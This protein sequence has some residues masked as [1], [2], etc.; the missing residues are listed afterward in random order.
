MLIFDLGK[1]QKERDGVAARA[2]IFFFLCPPSPVSCLGERPVVFRN[3]KERT[4]PK[5]ET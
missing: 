5:S 3:P 1:I 4:F 2:A